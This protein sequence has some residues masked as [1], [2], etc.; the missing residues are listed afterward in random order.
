MSFLDYSNNNKNNHDGINIR[1][2]F[3]FGR[4]R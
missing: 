4:V 3:T 1:V 2:N